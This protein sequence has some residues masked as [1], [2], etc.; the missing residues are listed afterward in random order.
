MDR[1]GS[2]WKI[3]ANVFLILISIMLISL[4]WLTYENDRR[5]L[6][7]TREAI[8][9]SA[10]AA[11]RADE[12]ASAINALRGERTE[13]IAALRGERTELIATL[14]KH[15]ASLATDI[16]LTREVM[17]RAFTAQPIV[18]QKFDTPASLDYNVPDVYRGDSAKRQVTCPRQTPATAVLL[19]AGQSNAANHVETRHVAGAN[20]LNFSMY[21]GRCYET[22]D[23]LI[24]ATGTGGNFASWLGDELVRRGEYKSV[25]LVT[26]AVGGTYINEW[27][28][29]GRLHRRFLAAI[30]R[31]RQAHLEIT[32]VLWQQ[33]EADIR[34]SNGDLYA[35][36]FE[37]IFIS[38]R[39]H[40]VL[41][42]ILVA[43]GVYCGTTNEE[44]RRGQAK[45]VNP[46]RRIFAGPDTDTLGR[47]FRYDNCHFNAHG[48]ER[49]AAL[50]ADAIEAA[51]MVP[52]NSAP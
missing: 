46:G 29:G 23:P 19:I 49:Q 25:I 35:E 18:L 33:G 11:G 27:A 37:D 22:A 21:D 40:G 48:A 8:L 43:R 30:E 14:N 24:A 52:D 2:N 10:A 45:I 39:R 7:R 9:W 1:R 32:H 4:F 50:W 47:E 36:I 6:S 16:P 20:V 31:A 51:R 3:N 41:A 38:L 13:L 28:P 5:I 15:V 17:L 42:P 44:T 26:I 34:I 12:M